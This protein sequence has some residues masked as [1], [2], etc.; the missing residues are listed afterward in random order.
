MFHDE[1]ELQAAIDDL[2]THGFDRS[3]LSLL[4]NAETVE[5][6]L[7]HWVQANDSLEDDPETPRI[8]YIARESVGDAEGAVIGGL[9]YVG[10]LAGLIPVVASGGAIPAMIAAGAAGGGAGAAIGSVLARFIGKQ[11]ADYID[12]H[13][14]RGGVVLWVRTWDQS[15]EARAVEIL[16]RQGGG[17]VHVHGL[18]EAE[19]A[20]PEAYFATSDERERE[21]I[22]DSL[23]TARSGGGYEALGRSFTQRED[24]RAFA[25]RRAA[26]LAFEREPALVGFDLAQAY[27]DPDRVFDGPGDLLAKP[28]PAHM[29]LELLRRWA[30]DARRLQASG[31]Q[32]ASSVER[33]GR[34][35][36][37]EAAIVKL[38]SEIGRP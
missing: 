23:V 27:V 21:E 37:I 24:A 15:D 25:A 20:I 29:K 1:K 31:A 26:R 36:E 7:G 3:D 5:R 28:L 9:L 18:A 16:T 19:T 10:A 13:L 35:Q 33:I 22:L 2:M 32:D 4:A 34:L 8:P 17:D 6:R 12:E 38:R 14:Q 11:R 30:Y